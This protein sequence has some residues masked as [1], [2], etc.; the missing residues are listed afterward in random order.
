MNT[1]CQ[2]FLLNFFLRPTEVAKYY[3]KKLSSNINEDKLINVE[4]KSTENFNLFSDG[5][6]STTVD[7]NLTEFAGK[8]KYFVCLFN[9]IILEV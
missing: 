8:G 1:V 5:E 2:T 9:N 4:P 6:V 7:I 3:S